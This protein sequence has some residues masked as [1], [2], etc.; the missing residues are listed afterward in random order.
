M[1]KNT[2]CDMCRR[3]RSLDKINVLSYISGVNSTQ[4][5]LQHAVYF[6]N[7]VEQC[8][9]RAIEKMNEEKFH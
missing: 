6:C 4:V 1:N 8:K 9:E 2:V 5:Y 3:D 7:D